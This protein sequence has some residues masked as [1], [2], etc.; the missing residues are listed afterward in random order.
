VLSMGHRI[1]SKAI[2]RGIPATQSIGE[3]APQPIRVSGKERFTHLVSA[4]LLWPLGLGGMLFGTCELLGLLPSTAGNFP[5]T[6]LMWILAYPAWLSVTALFGAGVVIAK[7]VTLGKLSEGEAEEDYPIALPLIRNLCAMVRLINWLWPRPLRLKFSVYM[8]AKI[9]P[10][11]VTDESFMDLA[12]ADLFTREDGTFFSSAAFLEFTQ[13]E[14]GRRVF[15]PIKLS[16][17]SYVGAYSTIV[18]PQTISPLTLVGACSALDAKNTETEAG[19]LIGVPAR[20]VPLRM[21]DVDPDAFTVDP[22]GLRRLNAMADLHRYLLF[23]LTVSVSS[24]TVAL[25]SSSS[26]VAALPTHLSH[27]LYLFGAW[28]GV[29]A[30]FTALVGSMARSLRRKVDANP[31]LTQEGIGRDNPLLGLWATSLFH[32]LPLSMMTDILSGTQLKTW[33]AR[34]LGADVGRGVYLDHGIGLSDLPYLTLEDDVSINE[35]A[36]LIAHSELP[37]GNISFKP[38]HLGSQSSVLWSGYL[39]GG[40]KLPRGAILGSLSRP[41]DSQT[42]DEQ[43]EYNNTPCR[44]KS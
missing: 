28:F 14:N 42:L 38:L 25:V 1:A 7:Q 37:N 21:G 18:G 31:R 4:T 20:P 23:T 16:K 32:M 39:V 26:A 35:G 17:G 29:V 30:A 33:V 3:S 40:T 19:A 44:R 11:T 13:L 5:A 10:N 8:G 22:A 2:A 15:H 27:A 36:A 34:L 6:A 24:G 43:T 12:Y 41:F 9:H